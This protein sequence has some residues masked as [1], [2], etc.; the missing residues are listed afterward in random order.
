MIQEFYYLSIIFHN[1][2]DL[3]NNFKITVLV[4]CMTE[5]QKIGKQNFNKI[6][7]IDDRLVIF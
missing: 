6:T 2:A 3:Q 4:F 1:K 7:P 5:L